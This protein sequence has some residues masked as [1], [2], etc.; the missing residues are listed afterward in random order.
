MSAQE[1]YLKRCEQRK[2]RAHKVKTET[3]FFFGGI[4]RE[5]RDK[6]DWGLC[7]DYHYYKQTIPRIGSSAP[8]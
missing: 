6:Q 7:G 8:R 3:Q 2:H 4:S 5:E 1:R